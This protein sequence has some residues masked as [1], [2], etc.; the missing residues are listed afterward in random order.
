MT[1]CSYE[2]SIPADLVG[3]QY[4]RN[5][6]NPVINNDDESARESHWFD[7]DGMLSGMLFRRVERGNGDERETI[8]QPEFVN[9]Y[10]V[11]DVYRFAQENQRWMRRPFMPS[12]SAL[13]DPCTSAVRVLLKVLRT[14]ALVLLS[15]L[16]GW[17]KTRVRRISVANTWVL[18]HDGR[19]LATCESGP[20]LRFLLPSLETVGW[21]NG[22][23]IE[24]E[25]S[26]DYGKINRAGGAG[27]GGNGMLSFMREWM[28]AHPRVDLETE[29]LIAFHSFP[30]KP[31]LSYSIIPQSGIATSLRLMSVPVPGMVG[32]KMMHDFGVS[33]H[34]T[35]IMDIPLSL[36]PLNL[37]KGRPVLSTDGTGKARFGIFPRYHPER[38][39]WVETNPCCIFHAANCWDSISDGDANSPEGMERRNVVNLLVCRMTSAS[40]IFNAG[41]LPTP[42]PKTPI[43][44]EYQEKEQCRL[45]YYSFFLTSRNQ[46]IL[47]Q[48]ALS[49]IPFEFPTVPCPCH[50]PSP[51]YLRLHHHVSFGLIY[52]QPRQVRQDRC[53][54]EGCRHGVDRPWNCT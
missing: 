32:P 52:Q 34:H 53:L 18:Y 11:T 43:P 6:G 47:H 16:P 51:L 48:F 30:V 44:P 31:Y 36:N 14:V 19:A 8:I 5:G 12:I 13:L 1:P 17:S 50:D 24:N 37:F 2:G 40:L 22:A 42:V 7:G 41:N 9:Q 3:G 27:F 25:P 54:G 35:V 46:R 21:F 33:K 29:E 38:V 10:L 20:P 26:G 49:A 4:V 45:N 28:T 15:W 39:Q 23:T